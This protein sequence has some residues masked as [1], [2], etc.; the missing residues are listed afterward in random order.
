MNN[1]V[2]YNAAVAGV[3]GGHL[4]RLSRINIT[5]PSAIDMSAVTAIATAIDAGIPEGEY[6]SRSID[7]IRATCIGFF[8]R[9]S[10]LTP[11]PRIINAIIAVHN[12]MQAALEQVDVVQ[13][14]P[15]EYAAANIL[16]GTVIGQTIIWDVEEN[17]YVPLL[18]SQGA[19]FY[20]IQ[21]LDEVPDVS[22][23]RLENS[24]EQSFAVFHAGPKLFP[25][26][27]LFSAFV[28][29]QSTTVE[30]P[31]NYVLAHR[32]ADVGRIEMRSG[33][34][35]YSQQS[36]DANS[37]PANTTQEYQQKHA[38]NVMMD[39]EFSRSVLEI[40]AEDDILKLGWRIGNQATGYPNTGVGGPRPTLDPR[41]GFDD[42]IP[43]T[44]TILANLIPLPLYV[45]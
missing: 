28:L 30:G 31:Y 39:N 26:D 23:A 9:Y 8:S 7:M 5:A 38:F 18:P 13:S 14:P 36:F 24:Q 37:S 2:V 34:T 1:N 11:E 12:G 43:V 35:I 29:S 10:Y 44:P 4:Q 27:S 3:M 21:A 22:H 19:R 15:G 25:T 42:P 41:D 16:P 6:T 45:D 20:G 17:A 40:Y 32:A 33:E